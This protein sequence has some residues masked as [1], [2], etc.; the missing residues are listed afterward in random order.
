MR[1]QPGAPRHWEPSSGAVLV[2]APPAHTP[3]IWSHAARGDLRP[4]T[5]CA[6]SPGGA[7]VGGT[8]FYA[9]KP[10]SPQPRAAPVVG[11]GHVGLGPLPT[12]SSP[13]PMLAAPMP[14]ANGAEQTTPGG[15]CCWWWWWCHQH[16]LAR[17]HQGGL[18]RGVLWGGGCS[19][20]LL[21]KG[22]P[23]PGGGGQRGAGSGAAP[24]SGNGEGDVVRT[25]AEL[26]CSW[27]GLFAPRRGGLL[28]ATSPRCSG[29]GARL[30]RTV[31]TPCATF[32]SG[33]LGAGRAA[34][35]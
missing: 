12:N 5:P 29:P 34:G 11:S 33:T 31:N 32:L 22:G 7:R 30:S 10:R 27:P 25:G 15:G 26:C 4:P 9:L 3:R 24:G 16:P 14:Q 6:C 21:G 28:G 8:F 2:P 17:G 19:G 20:S 23:G 35:G 18:S 13:H 1:G